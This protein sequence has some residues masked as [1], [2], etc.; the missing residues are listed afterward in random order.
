MGRTHYW[1]FTSNRGKTAQMEKV[2]QNAI[3]KCAKMVRYYSDTFG[4]L[5]GYTAHDV[6]KRY[7]GLNVNGSKNSGRG[8]DFTMREHLTQNGSD[9]CKTYSCPYDTVVV[10]CLIVLKHY[11]GDSIR[12]TSDGGVSDWADGLLLAQRVLNLKTVRIP[13]TII[14]RSSRAS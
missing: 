4:G 12:V 13:D 8:E 11:L 2:Y 1:S 6:S 14:D 3:V 9:Y 5:S 10:A 7:G